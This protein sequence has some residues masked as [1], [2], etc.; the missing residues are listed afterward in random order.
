MEIRDRMLRGVLAGLVATAP[1]SLAMGAMKRL[2]PWRE[3]YPLPPHQITADLAEKADAAEKMGPWARSVAAAVGHFS[4]GAAQGG[5]Y[6]SIARRLP[7][8]AVLKGVT[9]GLAVWAGSYLG[10]LP[11]T[12]IYRP[13]TEYPARRNALMIAAHV[14][15]GAGLGLLFAAG[16]R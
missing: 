7:G 3:R 1:M 13:A 9:F 5:L 2:L 15:W 10:L 11:L 6:G 16:R 12:G 14:V 4:Y 8:P